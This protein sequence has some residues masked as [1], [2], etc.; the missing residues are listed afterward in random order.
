MSQTM[1]GPA[2]F[3]RASTELRT[4]ALWLLRSLK[5]T[6]WSTCNVLTRMGRCIAA[7]CAGG[8]AAHGPCSAGCRFRHAG[9]HVVNPHVDVSLVILVPGVV[10]EKV[11]G[12]L[13]RSPV[14]LVVRV[15]RLFPLKAHQSACA[16]SVCGDR[17]LCVAALGAHTCLHCRPC[18]GHRY[19]QP[20]RSVSREQTPAQSVHQDAHLNKPARQAGRT[21]PKPRGDRLQRGPLQLLARGA[22]TARQTSEHS[23]S[24]MR[25]ASPLR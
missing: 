17:R 25:T 18:T 10:Y 7:Q 14:P 15:C 24:R 22:C 23:S 19:C 9:A 6:W 12:L 13:Q 21:R 3:W 11:A 1:S 8:L 16:T 5:L 2:H 20:A 4:G